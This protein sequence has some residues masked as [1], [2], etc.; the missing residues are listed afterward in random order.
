VRWIAA[1]PVAL[2]VSQILFSAVDLGLTY[3]RSMLVLGLVLGTLTYLAE[4]A[5]AG[6]RTYPVRV[7]AAA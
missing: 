5:T 4:R 1:L 7:G 2:V 6:A 3:S